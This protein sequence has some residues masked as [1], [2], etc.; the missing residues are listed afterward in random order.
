MSEELNILIISAASIAFF[1]TVFGPDHYLP[2]IVM[3]KARKWTMLKTSWITFLCGL[4][5]VGGSILL[6]IIG[7]A[8][9]IGISKI[10][11]FESFRGGLAAWLFIIFGFSYFLWGIWRAKR[12]KPHQHLHIHSDRTTH[13]HDHDHIKDHDHIHK[14]EKIIN[15]TPWV[16]FTIFV[17][18]PCEPLIPLLM[19]PA[20][21]NSKGGLVMVIMI[22]GI[23][24][25]ATMLGI[26]LIASFGINLLPL[27]R[28]EKYIHA[29][30]GAIIF[31][32]GVG[33]KFLGL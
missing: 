13:S 28:M 21:Q 10:E 6:G 2:F 24:T 15:L 12:G 31:L 5:H 26:V 16:L 25:I 8:V 18:G 20:A 27:R 1:H 4:G 17:L 32:S 23:I 29:I 14:K 9:G 33:I 7:I 11:G 3:A 19:Y 30:A 22:F